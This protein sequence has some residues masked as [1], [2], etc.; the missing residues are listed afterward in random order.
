MF[1]FIVNKYKQ[2]KIQNMPSNKIKQQALLN[3]LSNQNKLH[4][5]VPRQV[6]GPRQVYRQVP[7]QGHRKVQNL[8]KSFNCLPI[9]YTSVFNKNVNKIINI[10]QPHYINGRSPGF[11][12]Y[13]RG[14]I[15]LYQISKVLNIE[16]DMDLSHHPLSSFLL[17]NN[18]NNID[19]TNISFYYNLNNINMQTTN[20]DFLNNFIDNLNTINEVTYSLFSNAFPIY[21]EITQEC[22]NFIKNKITPNNVIEQ[23]IND[24]LNSMQLNKHN[25]SILHI[26]SGDNYLINDDNYNINYINKL[27]K[28]ISQNTNNNT[29]YIILSDSIKLKKLI[30]LRFS[31]FYTE[32]KQ[33]THIG[34]L[35]INTSESI[36]NTLTDFYLMSYS[37]NI[38]SISSYEWG[39]G[40]SEWCSIIY[41]I[42]YLKIV[43][44]Q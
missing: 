13:L 11:G 25:Y 31:N 32:L 8:V 3:R 26:R 39:S 17:N 29:T 27:Y 34:E 2:Q 21:S 16:F 35:S 40:F 37:Q 24:I 15:C 10:Y 36:I 28:I 12:D 23:N 44:T 22:K 43:I 14:C 20:P 7:R 33:I 4:R 1:N 18:S 6:Q 42:P 5:Q 41:N 38:I 19:Y 9:K 30:K